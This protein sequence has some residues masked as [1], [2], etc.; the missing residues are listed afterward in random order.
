MVPVTQHYNLLLRAVRD[1]SLG[2]ENY[3]QLLINKS[4]KSHSTLVSGQTNSNL[5]RVESQSSEKWQENAVCKEYS[6]M[7]SGKDDYHQMQNVTASEDLVSIKF[8]S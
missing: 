8:S 2:D 1:C 7:D 3:V 4:P 6:V 5:Y